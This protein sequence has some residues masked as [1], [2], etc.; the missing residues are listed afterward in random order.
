MAVYEHEPDLDYVF[1]PFRDATTGNETYAGGR[2]LE[3]ELS[4]DGKLVLD[5]NDAYLPWCAYSDRWTCSLPP[6]ENWL[7]VAIEAGEKNYK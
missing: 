2:Y 3:P 7:T 6:I 5:F 1:V 4:K